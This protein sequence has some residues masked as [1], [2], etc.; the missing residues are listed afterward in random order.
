M[1]TTL[2]PIA[3]SLDKLTAAC[4]SGDRSLLDSVIKKFGREFWQFDEM[5]EDLG[6][7]GEDDEPAGNSIT[8]KEALGHLI[9]GEEYNQKAGFLYNGPTKG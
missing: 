4:G 8:M 9:M 6:H 1:G 3:V 7:L 5:G 2:T